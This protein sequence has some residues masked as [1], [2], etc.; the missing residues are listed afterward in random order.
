VIL[1]R[2]S[3]VSAENHEAPRCDEKTD[4]AVQK[5]IKRAGVATAAV[6]VQPVPFVEMILISP[7]QIAMVRRIGSLRGYKFDRKAAYEIWKAFRVSILTQQ[8]VI[9]AVK[10]VPAI[11]SIAAASVAYSLTT[12]IGEVFDYYYRHERKTPAGELLRLF[13]QLLAQK[14]DQSPPDEVRNIEEKRRDL[15][16]L[17]KERSERKLSSAEYE[18][19][20]SEILSRV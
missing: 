19:R 15:N 2:V 8:A 5:D 20:K 16:A 12:T 4:D 6:A 17:A 10:F 14:R 7:I 11:G 1:H 9:T 3:I 18:R 13:K